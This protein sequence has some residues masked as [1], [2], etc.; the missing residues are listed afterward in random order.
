[1]YFPKCWSVSLREMVDFLLMK[2]LLIVFHI[3][4]YFRL[5]ALIIVMDKPVHAS[6]LGNLA[7]CFGSGDTM[8][9]LRGKQCVVTWTGW[10]YFSNLF[11]LE[12]FISPLAWSGIHKCTGSFLYEEVVFR[13]KH[14]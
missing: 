5:V 12:H 3:I 1:M 9:A 7:T 14:V 13:W 10:A 2:R 4:T 11:S 8:L 6:K